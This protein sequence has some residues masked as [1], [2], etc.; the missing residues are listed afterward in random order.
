MV[1]YKKGEGGRPSVSFSFFIV[2]VSYRH[3]V[4]VPSQKRMLEA[5]TLLYFG[6][7]EGGEAF[8][9]YFLP[10]GTPRR[11]RSAWPPQSQ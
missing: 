9:A 5:I 2:Y 8:I 11:A 10:W 3:P 6:E 4:S 7:G 1:M